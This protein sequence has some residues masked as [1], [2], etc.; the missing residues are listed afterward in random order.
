MS[1]V[2]A[3]IA[4]VLGLAVSGNAAASGAFVGKV[5]ATIGTYQYKDEING[6]PNAD[7]DT[8]QY[9]LL[10]GMGLTVGR[11]FADVGVEQYQYTKDRDTDGDGFD[12][13][14]YY[15][16]DF[17]LNLGAFI[18]DHWTAFAGYRY[19]TQG[20]GAFSDDAGYTADGPLLGGGFSF[21]AGK[22]VAIGAS[23]AYNFLTFSQ[24]GQA[25]NDFDLDGISVKLQMAFVGTP[26]AIFLRGQR[27][28]GEQTFSG[29]NYEATEDYFNVG[30]QATFDFASW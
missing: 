1:R 13:D 24:Q 3:G 2:S 5:G 12:D 28:N 6:A 14:A 19:S 9:G 30:Y 22:K 10:L 11:F 8:N 17:L 16:S 21:R 4:M 18:G 15:R 29:G 27:F 20:D 7:Y 26:H 25:V 23:A